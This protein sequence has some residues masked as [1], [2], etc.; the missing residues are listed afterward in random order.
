MVLRD[1]SIN[2]NSERDKSV[3][4]WSWGSYL[5]YNAIVSLENCKKLTSQ[6][7]KQPSAILFILST[8]SAIITHLKS[9]EH[10]VMSIYS[11][12]KFNFSRLSV[13]VA[14]YLNGL[15]QLKCFVAFLTSWHIIS[16][17]V[18]PKSR[19]CLYVVN[20]HKHHIYYTPLWSSYCMRLH[21]EKS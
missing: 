7:E 15:K 17:S 6:W 5:L 13:N 1:L 9:Y 12:V 11:L 18:L 20:R 4:F 21:Y 19:C 14:L 8:A 16:H 10:S 3:Y 2:L